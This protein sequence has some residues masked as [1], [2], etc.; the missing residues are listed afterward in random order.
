MFKFVVVSIIVFLSVGRAVAEV[1]TFDLQLSGAITDTFEVVIEGDVL[2]VNSISFSVSGTVEATTYRCTTYDWN[3][4]D[5]WYWESSLR[6]SLNVSARS[7]DI[8]AYGSHFFRT[9]GDFAIEN[10]VLNCTPGCEA[11]LYEGR[12]DVF[13][14]PYRDISNP[15]DCPGGT[16]D[17]FGG[18]FNLDGNSVTLTVDYNS[19]V[20]TTEDTWGAV[21][22]RYR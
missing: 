11:L 5:S 8:Y 10:Q 6:Y 2:S 13:V 17:I 12:M 22:A 3:T 19:A 18:F 15:E 14:G 9:D 21:K 7:G 4:G 20:A 16:E 1:A